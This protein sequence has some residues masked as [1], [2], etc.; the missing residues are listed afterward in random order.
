VTNYPTDV[1][2]PSSTARTQSNKVA[3]CQVCHVSWQVQSMDSEPLDAQGCDFCGAPARCVTI[4]SEA[5]DF[6]QLK[7]RE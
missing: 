2:G 4:E 6:G 7:G 1:H 3:R 5:P